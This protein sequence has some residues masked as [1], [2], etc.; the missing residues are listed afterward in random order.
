MGTGDRRAAPETE[1]R[2]RRSTRDRVG[3]RAVAS[4]SPAL[5]AIS[6]GCPAGIGPEVSV[7]AAW[8][9]RNLDAVLVGDLGTLRAAAKVVG[10]RPERLVSAGDAAGKAKDGTL[11]VFEVGPRLSAK[12]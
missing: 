11:R 12:D 6:T 2:P 9:L 8:K 5:L 3:S 1:T 7:A 10:V 4:P